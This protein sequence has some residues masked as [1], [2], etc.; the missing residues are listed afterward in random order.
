M[1]DTFTFEAVRLVSRDTKEAIYIRHPKHVLTCL[2]LPKEAI[3]N[4]SKSG[5]QGYWWIEIPETLAEKKGLI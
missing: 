1:S 4:M 3:I 5:K 2:F